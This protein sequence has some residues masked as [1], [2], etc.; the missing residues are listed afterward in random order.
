MIRE[1][2]QYETWSL[3]CL[4]GS[5]LVQKEK[6]REKKHL[7]RENNSYS[8]LLDETDSLPAAK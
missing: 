4:C 7:W 5:P 8:V 6:S 1:V 2:Q 3:N